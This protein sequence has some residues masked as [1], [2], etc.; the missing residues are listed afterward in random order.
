MNNL[1]EPVDN[2]S[3]Y[4]FRDKLLQA[5][6]GRSG[7][8][9]SHNRIFTLENAGLHLLVFYAHMAQKQFY[10]NKILLHKLQKVLLSRSLLLAFLINILLI[11]WFVP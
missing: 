7:F 3:N 2:G 1:L 11:V 5:R 8:N 4:P 9:W 6:Q 10:T